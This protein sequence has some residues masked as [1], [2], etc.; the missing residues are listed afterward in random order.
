L[1]A[2]SPIGIIIS[3]QS[4][5]AFSVQGAGARAAGLGG[6][7]IAVADDATAVS[8]NPAGLAQ[9]LKPEVS[10]VGRGY[11]RD[12]AYEDVETTAGT[13]RLLVSDSL[14]SSSRF[15]PLF[16]SGSVPLLVG[17]RTLAL[18]LSIQRLIPLGERDSRDLEEYPAAFNPGS[19]TSALKQSIDQSGQI[20]LY[21]FAASY[22]VSQ[23]ILAGI[24]VNLWRGKW[25]LASQSFKTTGAATSFVNF[26]QSNRLE[27][28]N[29]NLGLIWRWPTWS[30]G[31]VHRTAFHGDY[32]FGTSLSTSAN[33]AAVVMDPVATGLHWPASTGVGFAYRPRERWLATVD[34]TRTP[35]S[36][37]RYMTPNRGLNGLSFFD[38]DKGTRT[39]DSTDF[40]VGVEHLILTRAG[41]VVPLRAGFSREPQPVVDRITGEQRVIYGLSAGSG[42][43]R[44]AVTLDVAYRFG[45]GRRRASQFLD[46]DQIIS[47]TPPTS[48]GTE[49]IR[50]H[51]LDFSLIVQFEQQPV[52]RVLR[53]LFVGD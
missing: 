22:E 49:R 34:V 3:E 51:K 45:W 48:L 52:A 47:N 8:F 9:L 39:P 27:G 25:D 2:Q 6:A 15:D 53:H 26:R 43:K 14:I 20:D 44:G 40:R 46:V 42:L 24:A 28:V 36:K 38:L 23:R 30:M 29:Y 18:Q 35:W 5:T 4:R 41:S 17:D 50:E 16:V 7:F 21:S 19:P 10:F 32:T 13:K 11:R 1:G 37:A 12:V 31:L 33:T